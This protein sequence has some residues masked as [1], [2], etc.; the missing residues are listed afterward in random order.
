MN[1]TNEK[2]WWSRASREQKLAQIDGGI[3]CGM[4]ARHIAVNLGATTSAVHEYGRRN[5]RR[6]T[7][8]NTRK[9]QSRAGSIAG[10]GNARRLGKPDC[11][12]ASA[13]S[14]F[15]DFHSEKPMFDE[16]PA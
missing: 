9:Q 12:I 6:F 13:F 14:I 10:L 11:E 1:K 15:G 3:E 4:S 16:V 7:G 2:S 8:T 5:G